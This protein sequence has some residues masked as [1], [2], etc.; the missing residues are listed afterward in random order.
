MFNPF[1]RRQTDEDAGELDEAAIEHRVKAALARF[2]EE[3]ADAQPGQ[4][5]AAPAAD[6]EIE[7]FIGDR[8]RRDGIVVEATVIARILELAK[9]YSPTSEGR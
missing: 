2:Q 4:P 3:N 7:S 1:G 6:G 8:L 9:A 5:P